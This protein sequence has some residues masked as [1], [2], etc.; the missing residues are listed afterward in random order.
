MTK[1]P[2]QHFVVKSQGSLK[3]FK[4]KLTRGEIFQE[5]LLIIELLFNILFSAANQCPP[6]VMQCHQVSCPLSSLI[7]IIIQVENAPR[8][9][10]SV[11]AISHAP[12][13]QLSQNKIT[14]RGNFAQITS[15]GLSGTDE[16]PSLGNIMYLQKE[17]NV[18]GIQILRQVRCGC[19][20]T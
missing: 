20:K 6:I 11:A 9:N 12:R 14:S 18:L 3:R 5:V 2:I 16:P 15:N 4:Q 8:S 13:I 1:N 17:N 19:A 10:Y 7:I